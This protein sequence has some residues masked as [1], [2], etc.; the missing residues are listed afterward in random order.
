[1][2]LSILESLPTIHGIL[3]GIGTAFFSGFAMLAYQKIQDS[4]DSL[5]AV[6]AEVGDFSKS[7]AYIGGG[8][9]DNLIQE[10]GSLNWH[11]GKRILHSAKSLLSAQE[12]KHGIPGSPHFSEPS[13]SEIC[14]VNRSLCVLLSQ[15]FVS[16]P[17]N[18]KS[19]VHVSGVSERVELKKSEPF[20]VEQLQEIQ[21]RVFFLSW[22][23]ETSSR[24]L[25]VLGQRSSEIE[26]KEDEL[27]YRKVYEE[28]LLTHIRNGIDISE[29]EKERM[30]NTSFQLRLN[31]QADYARII[32]DFFNKVL[33]YRDRVLPELSNSLKIHRLFVDRFNFKTNTLIAFKVIGYVFI[34]GVLAPIVLLALAVDIELVWHPVLPYF[35]LI[36]TVFPYIYLWQKLFYKF[37][38][39]SF[40]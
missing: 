30:W 24:S 9:N 28:T 27:E 26:R 38:R 19:S 40:E 4:E 31:G 1:M 32:S 18:G 10:D 15:L 12:D 17:F 39:L 5:N 3:I 2:D 14:S 6:L 34:F 20:T 29:A 33:V 21:R 35:L 13:D 16:Y 37:R 8:D 25:I 36:V 7:S 23:W 22:C 11:E